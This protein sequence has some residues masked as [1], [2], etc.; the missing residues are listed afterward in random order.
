MLGSYSKI[1]NGNIAPSRFV[2]LDVSN[3]GRAI[4]CGTG[5]AA[6]GISQPSTRNL[7]LS[8]RDD[9]YAAIAGE[10]V[11]II[12]PGDDEGLLELGG[13][14]TVGDYLKSDTDGKGVTSSSDKEHVNA[15]ALQS[16]VS[17]DLVLVKPMRFDLAA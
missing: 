2:K 13:T 5:E 8:G 7:A 6:F 4:Q 11:N 16:G 17:G 12:G 1:A 3:Q 15:Q 14:V 9:G 10:N